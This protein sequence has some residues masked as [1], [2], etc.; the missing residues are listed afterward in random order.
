MLIAISTTP[1]IKDAKVNDT[2]TKITINAAVL[3]NMFIEYKI[4]RTISYCIA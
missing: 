4:W 3:L 2:K 1:D